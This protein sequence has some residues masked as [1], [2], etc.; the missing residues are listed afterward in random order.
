[1]NL[2]NYVKN[3]GLILEFAGQH[4]RLE[5][6]ESLSVVLRKNKVPIGGLLDRE[7]IGWRPFRIEVCGR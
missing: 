1:M 5:A 6:D 2:L 4:P 7:Y 3:L